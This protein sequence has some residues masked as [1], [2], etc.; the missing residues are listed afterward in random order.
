MTAKRNK[1]SP[2]KRQAGKREKEKKK[3]TYYLLTQLIPT[4]STTRA[5]RTQA[6]AHPNILHLMEIVLVQ[7]PDERRKVRVLEHPGEDRFR[8]FCHLL[9]R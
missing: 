2:K 8:E 4:P 3:K 6:Q 7:L 5:R 9:E 1:I